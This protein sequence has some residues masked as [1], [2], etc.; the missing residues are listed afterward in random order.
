MEI[1]REFCLK[2]EA[3]K[4]KNGKDLVDAEEIKKRWKGCM[5]KPHKKD[6]N[7]QMTM[8]VWSASQSQTF[9]RQKSSTAANKASGC[10]GTPVELFKTLK[11]KGIYMLLSIYEHI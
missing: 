5:E 1:S 3:I 10:D 11:D 6:L 2:M 8:M 4:D 9:R 7:D